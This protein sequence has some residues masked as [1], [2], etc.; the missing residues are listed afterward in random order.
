MTTRTKPRNWHA[1]DEGSPTELPN[2]S[3]DATS[4]SAR[5][6]WPQQGNQPE[7]ARARTRSNSSSLFVFL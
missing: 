6:A 5:L 1:V 7:Q 3:E 2:R 4:E